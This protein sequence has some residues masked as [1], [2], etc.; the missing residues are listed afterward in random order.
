MRRSLVI[1]FKQQFT[2]SEWW[3]STIQIL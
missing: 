1:G 3:I 2:K